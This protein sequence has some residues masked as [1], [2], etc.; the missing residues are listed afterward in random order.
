MKRC[1]EPDLHLWKWIVS[2][3]IALAALTI[4]LVALLRVP[5][6]RL[7][8]ETVEKLKQKAS[9]LQQQQQQQDNQRDVQLHYN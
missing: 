7:H 3:V 4:S 5:T 1:K 9:A 8:P 6:V 2:M